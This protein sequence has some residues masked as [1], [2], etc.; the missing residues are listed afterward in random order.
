MLLVPPGSQACVPALQALGARW[1][2]RRA[3]GAPVLGGRK[4]VGRHHC[5]GLLLAFL[6]LDGVTMKVLQF[7]A[8]VG[9]GGFPGG[10]HGR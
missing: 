10:S 7:W 4:S 3:P 9:E 2:Q 6:A 8:V 5:S 1:G